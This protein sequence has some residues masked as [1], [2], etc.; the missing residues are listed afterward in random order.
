MVTF[1]VVKETVLHANCTNNLKLPKIL[2]IFICKL[3][4]TRYCPDKI[5]PNDIPYLKRLQFNYI[6]P[7]GKIRCGIIW[8]SL[9]SNSSSQ[10]EDD[11]RRRWVFDSS[12]DLL[13]EESRGSVRTT[14]LRLQQWRGGEDGQTQ[15]GRSPSLSLSPTYTPRA[16]THPFPSS[17]HLVGG[18]LEEAGA[19]IAADGELERSSFL[20]FEGYISHPVVLPA[21]TMVQCV[22]EVGGF[23]DEQV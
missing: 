19:T 11:L 7:T 6:M 2:L 12:E 23:S 13:V 20:P 8:V 5:I 15:A 16:H 18:G 14:S 1:S 3:I 10:N 9:R 4:F 22:W 17:S 21:V